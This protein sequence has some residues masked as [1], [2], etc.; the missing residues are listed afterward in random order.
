MQE[1]EGGRRKKD[2]LRKLKN[3]IWGMQ[4]SQGVTTYSIWKNPQ[5][6]NSAKPE[7]IQ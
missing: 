4:A 7:R 6:G 1:K 3:D 2:N 5:R